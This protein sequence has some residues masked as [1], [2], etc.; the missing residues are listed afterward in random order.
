MPP[1]WIPFTCPVFHCLM[2]S[3]YW[4]SIWHLWE[5]YVLF[6]CNSLILQYLQHPGA[7]PCFLLP[8]LLVFAAHEREQ[9][10]LLRF[11][12]EIIWLQVRQYTGLSSY[13]CLSFADLNFCISADFREPLIRRSLVSGVNGIYSMFESRKMLTCLSNQRNW[14]RRRESNS[15][16][17]R[18]FLPRMRHTT[19]RRRHVC[20]LSPGTLRFPRHVLVIN[21]FSF[22]NH[23]LER[24][25]GLEPARRL[26]L[27]G[28]QDPY[29][30]GHSRIIE[31]GEGFEPC[32]LQA[33]H[34]R[35][36]APH[37]NWSQLGDSN[38]W[39][40][41][42]KWGALSNWAKL[43]KTGADDRIRT[44]VGFRRRFTKPV[45]STAKGRQHKLEA[46]WR[47]ELHSV[48]YKTTASP[49]CLKARFGS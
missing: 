27:L 19:R 2:Y 28:R 9:K 46:H 15:R 41:H 6:E 29:H 20:G 1:D 11:S 18:T 33:C 38:P 24:E 47:I 22:K 37:S 42:Y 48:V 7:L 17:R 8:R 49:Q 44:C 12:Y 21:C 23:N 5:Q 35:T 30:W 43:A 16:F 10:T 26:H 39:H 45:L 25:T 40:P 36:S 4:N 14:S 34:V 32:L 31:C 13:C 3:L